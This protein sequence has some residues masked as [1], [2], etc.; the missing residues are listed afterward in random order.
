MNQLRVKINVTL[1]RPDGTYFDP[2]TILTGTLVELPE[3]IRLAIEKNKAYL[4]IAEIPQIE[5]VHEV[6]REEVAELIPEAIPAEIPEQEVV[7][8][9]KV[10]R[11]T[12]LKK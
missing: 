11:K 3:D 4:E 1:K 8:T 10:I 2:G 6:V 9:K 12:R 7:P 5:P